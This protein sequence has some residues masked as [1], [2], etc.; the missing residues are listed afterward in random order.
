[1]LAMLAVAALVVLRGLGQ[2]VYVALGKS[3]V[4]LGIMAGC[5]IAAIAIC[6]DRT[7]VRALARQ[8]GQSAT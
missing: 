1:M 4:G 2:E 7:F 8:H 3:D 6:V 5:A